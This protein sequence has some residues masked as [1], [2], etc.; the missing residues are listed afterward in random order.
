MRVTIFDS[1][2][3]MLFLVP[4]PG[5]RNNMAELPD[6]ECDISDETILHSLA[7]HVWEKTGMRITAVKQLVKGNV[8]DEDRN[9]TFMVDVESAQEVKLCEHEH[10]NFYWQTE[11][12][13]AE[14]KRKLDESDK[15]L[16]SLRKARGEEPRKSVCLEEFRLRRV[17]MSAVV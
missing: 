16:V 15:S 3:R 11:E 7:R 17:A 9:F 8:R 10:K 5:H 13:C 6:G 14:N 12:K 1:Q 2:G 4:V